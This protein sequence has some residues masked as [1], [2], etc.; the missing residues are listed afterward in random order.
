MA[1]HCPTEARRAYLKKNPGGKHFIRYPVRLPYKPTHFTLEQIKAAVDKLPREVPV[2]AE[3]DPV[4]AEAAAW[5]K[6]LNNPEGG[7]YK[8]THARHP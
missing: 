6:K 4:L 7:T 1:K 5:W 2:L 3:K 8:I